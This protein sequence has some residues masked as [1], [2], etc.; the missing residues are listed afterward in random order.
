MSYFL[1]LQFSLDLSICLTHQY[2]S[3]L[4]KIEAAVSSIHAS[5]TLV[6]LRTKII[7]ILSSYPFIFI[8][9][10]DASYHKET[11]NLYDKYQ[12]GS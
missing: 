11:L 4:V 3:T 8:S 2:I 7:Y 9:T 1:I 5:S 12:K 6:L 10:T